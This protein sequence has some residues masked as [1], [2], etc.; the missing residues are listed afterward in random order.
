MTII[1]KKDVMMKQLKTLLFLPLL[2]LVFTTCSEEQIDGNRIGSIKG[3]IVADGANNPLE[4]VKISTNPVS[5]TVFS[6]ENGD[7]LIENAIVGTYAVQAQLDGYITAFESV[8]VVENTAAAVAFEL[9]V[10]NANNQPPS[11][12]DLVFPE[13]LQTEVPFEVQFTWESSDP[14]ANDELSYVLELRNGATNEIELYETQQDTF[15]LAPNLALST[16][17]FWQVTVNDGVNDN[18]VSQISQFTTIASPNNPYFFVKQ[19]NG[20][21]V[22]YSGSDDGLN[23]DNAEI[24]IALLKLTSENNNS[25]RP[26]GNPVINKVAYLRNVGGNT[27]I[28][29][30]DTGGGNKTQVTSV[31]PVNGFR[32][33]EVDFCWA[34]NGSQLYYPNLNKLYRINSDGSGAVLIYQTTDGSFITEVE[35][36]AFDTDLLLIKTNDSSGYNARIFTYRLSANAEETVIVEGFPGALGGIDISANGDQV[37]YTRDL[38]GSENVNYRIFESRIFNYN[39]PSLTATQVLTDV[40][41]GENDL[42]GKYS[43]SEGGVIFTRAN[44]NMGAIPAIYSFQFGAT[45][46]EKQLFS[47]GSMPDWK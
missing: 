17:Y 45:I 9:L 24:D 5:S 31:I 43:P 41:S 34:Q 40:V 22:I 8:S 21:S 30:M 23:D 27:Q 13:D 25:F 29:T 19:E 12:P 4:N 33:N 16:T 14:D 1:N 47:A 26:R 38:S 18:V 6:D 35:E 28:F 36:A 3:K 2:L 7:F 20:N 10:S 39:I 11:V 32:I 42:D 37:L 15:Y 44:S 46:Q